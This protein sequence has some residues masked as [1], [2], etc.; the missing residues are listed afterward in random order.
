MGLLPTYPPLSRRQGALPILTPSWVAALVD[1][2]LR[3][4]FTGVRRPH[5]PSRAATKFQGGEEVGV[6]DC[7]GE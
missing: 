6:G 5:H 2:S 7:C 4:Q 3:G 1:Q